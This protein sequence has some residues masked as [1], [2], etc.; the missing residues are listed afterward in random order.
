MESKAKVPTKLLIIIAAAL[1]IASAAGAWL[2]RSAPGGKI[3]EVS[4]D[5]KVLYTIDLST[6]TSPYTIE[7]PG[8][9][10]LISPGSISVL[11]ADCPDKL[12]VA[13]GELSSGALPI[14]CLPN[15]L[16]IRLTDGGSGV[17]AVAGR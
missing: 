1:L 17:D 10:L 5:G 15:R 4:L 9:T 2:V 11:E 14:V 3:A 8:N 12:C 6:V 16:V 13:R 7:L